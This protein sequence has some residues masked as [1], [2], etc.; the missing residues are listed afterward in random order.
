MKKKAVDLLKYIRIPHFASLS[1]KKEFSPDAER[2]LKKDCLSY[3]I[4]RVLLTKKTGRTY[5][6]E[7]SREFELYE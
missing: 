6:I 7:S 4:Y 5:K 1:E 3:D 2:L